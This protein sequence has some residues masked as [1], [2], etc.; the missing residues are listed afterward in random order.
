MALLSVWVVEVT[1]PGNEAKRVY[2]SYAAAEA[3]YQVALRKFPQQC[4]YFWE[5]TATGKKR[6]RP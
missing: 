1:A 4:V 3:A 5:M 2:D 6:G